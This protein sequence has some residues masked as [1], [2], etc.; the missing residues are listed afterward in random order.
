MMPK[1]YITVAL[2]PLPPEFQHEL[3]ISLGPW[4][5]LQSLFLIQTG[6]ITKEQLLNNIRDIYSAFNLELW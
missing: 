2:N 4:T 5:H 6:R 3:S 1:G